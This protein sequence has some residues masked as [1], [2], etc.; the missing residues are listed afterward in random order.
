[1][2]RLPILLLLAFVP[3]C[4]GCQRR[5]AANASPFQQEA[6]EYVLLIAIDADYVKDNPKAFD[7]MA[8]ALE[9]YFQ[10]RIGSN[11]QVIL[12]QMS[13]SKRPLLWQGT[14]QAL[15]REFADH[16][17][18]RKFL[19]AH[20]ESG[21]RINDGI[22]ESLNYLM[23]TYS[24]AKGKAKSVALIVSNMIDDQPAVDESEPRLM[25]SLINY[26]HRGAMGFYFVDQTRMADIIDK[27]EKAGF[28]FYTLEPDFHGRP[29]LPSFE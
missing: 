28:R 22:A 2:R 19:L 8:Y 25:E 11:D 13:G 26:G 9:S 18:F 27:M 3:G 17:A 7:F 16:A 29:A 4:G 1:M 20:A 10:E 14:P 23:R 21:S 6:S 12:A 5:D 15:R 24:V